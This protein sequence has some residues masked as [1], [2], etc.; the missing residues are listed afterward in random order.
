MDSKCLQV[1]TRFEESGS[2][3]GF[4]VARIS[5]DV[6]SKAINSVLIAGNQ[7]VKS[8][9]VARLSRQYPT[10]FEIG[11]LGDNRR[12]LV[13]PEL[14]ARYPGKMPSITSSLI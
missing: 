10:S 4:G 7:L 1:L 3:H 8:Q 11:P 12:G 14:G 9:G 6:C 13:S 5:R 2:H